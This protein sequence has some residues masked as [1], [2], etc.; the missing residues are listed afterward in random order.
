M[1]FGIST[2]TNTGV[3][4]I[5]D[6]WEGFAVIQTGMTTAY[7]FSSDFATARPYTTFPALDTLPIIALR[8][9]TGIKVC[10]FDITTSGFR[11]MNMS[12][13][14]H[15]DVTVEYAVLARVST[16]GAQSGD[17]GLRVM[18]SAG[19]EVFSSLK[20]NLAID[21]TVN[22]SGALS[23]YTAPTPAFGRRF[24]V[25]NST[26]TVPYVGA[27]TLYNRISGSIESET[28]VGFGIWRVTD[29][30]PQN[31][32]YPY[33]RGPRFHASGLLI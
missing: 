26:G 12:G 19:V 7:R 4:Q 28:S 8:P 6:I 13:W 1:S 32:G 23:Y 17:F 30:T 31:L 11:L 3:T 21:F 25:A 27:G 14:N 10:K 29:N 9:P 15:T 2:T 18:N 22:H 33:D 20:S 24:F 16:V 5:D